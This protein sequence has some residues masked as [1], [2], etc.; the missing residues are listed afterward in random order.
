M[1][2][3]PILLLLITT[4]FFEY[5]RAKKNTLC[6]KLYG[7]LFNGYVPAG[8]M[9][10]GV[11]SAVPDAEDQRSC[12]LD[13]CEKNDCNVAFI[14]DEKCYHIKCQNSTIC[15]PIYIGSGNSKEEDDY[16]SRV[17]MVLVRPV[18]EDVEWVELL[19]GNRKNDE[20]TSMEAKDN[21]EFASMFSRKEELEND[22]NKLLQMEETRF[23]TF[24]DGC[25]V[26]IPDNC[27]LNEECIQNN[28][29]GRGG[30][31]KCKSGYLRNSEN[32]CVF[33]EKTITT[34]P[35]I[36]DIT[37]KMNLTQSIPTKGL[38]DVT[39]ESKVVKLPESEVSLTAVVNQQPGS[40]INPLKDVQYRY[41]WTA[42]TQPDGSSAVK[43]QNGETLQL[44]KLSEGL[45]TF[46][47][48][49][50]NETMYGET[51]VNV[52][53]LPPSRINKPPEIVITPANQTI[54]LPNNGAVLDASS[55]T[56]DDGIVT[57]HWELQQGPLGYQPQLHDTPTLELN[58]LNMP[59]NYTFKLT[60]T[61]TDKAISVSTANVTVLKIT[62]Y[63]P[64]ANAGQDT[65]IYLPHNQITLN[66]NQSIDD[67]MIT[68]WEWTKSPDDAEK[69][70][71]MQ[72]TRTPYLKLSDLEEGMY[73]FTLKVTD[74]A[75]QSST[76]QVHVF[77][78]PPTNKPPIANAGGNLTI[79][80]P[81]TWV[82]IDAGNSTDDNR[83]E[84]YK[85]EQVNGPST[86]T[87][88]NP[89]A[90]KTNVTG[91]TKGGYAFKVTVTDDN[92]NVASDTAFITVDQNKNQKPI[93]NAGGNLSIELPRNVVYVN[94]SKSTDDWSIVRWKW[95]RLEN[96]LSLGNIAEGSDETPILILTD[97]KSGI[98]AF[99]L[100]V[101]DEQG[102]SDSQTV[103][104]SVLDDP[105]LMFL[106]D[107][108]VDVEADELTES[109]YGILKGKLA[110][111]IE[112]NSKLQVRSIK[113]Q[114]GTTN[115][116]ITFYVE[117]GVDNQTPLPANDVVKH[118]RKKLAI[119]AGLLGF[120]ISRLQ[121]TI[122]Q[123]NCSG[124]GVCNELSRK[125]TCE[126]FWMEDL[127][128]IY[129]SDGYED[130]NCSW[131][132]L[133]V[134][135]GVLSFVVTVAAVIW[136]L[137]YL[138]LNGFSKRNRQKPA[139]YKLIQ[140]SDDVLP[141]SGRKADLSDSDTDSDVVFESRNKPSRFGDIRN[142][143][144]S[145]RNG[146]SKIGRRVKTKKKKNFTIN[147]A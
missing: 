94:G 11:F 123:N 77:V 5:N 23:P 93:A 120:T 37:S 143:H 1:W 22:Y 109:Q 88:V 79:S 18:E 25:E 100:T 106:V 140:D 121:T 46:K 29:R 138:C 17:S 6:P 118:L 126:S 117:S 49:V 86:V 2:T 28:V 64:E 7:K 34:T 80:L 116:I 41:E 42:L 48:A 105:K 146:F 68:T 122:C 8:N 12:V 75:N 36:F 74:S 96:S 112:D 127:F 53:V 103:Q 132:V 14:A 50:S 78:K 35:K 3:K 20:A 24:G 89:N 133:Y 110:L 114:P 45:Y 129:L 139:S 135:L 83:I 54:K 108:V 65:I 33:I 44:T 107:M 47:V 55:S 72:D 26:N 31:C 67:H 61:D 63:P 57:F 70:V 101:Y 82:V 15:L 39:A 147:R 76:A 9:S 81:Q 92:D 124:H 128:K 59:G 43:H 21:Y 69:A 19:L 141:Y 73:T 144:K 60:V 90:T 52:T 95:T 91:L 62:D 119:D 99:N 71:D 40:E 85:W 111:L 13:C 137:I 56:D 115:P 130:S 142:G 30:T 10:S 66:G 97:L 38:L 51:F 58:D 134:V 84:K 104:I 113:Q 125:C 87:F 98:Y 102:L 16:A 136:A 145:I 131:S 4:L 27:P 32:E